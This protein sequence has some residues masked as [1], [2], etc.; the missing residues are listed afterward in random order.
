MRTLY[1]LVGFHVPLLAFLMVPLSLAAA[2]EVQ[3]AAAPSCDH[4]LVGFQVPHLTF[5]LYCRCL[6]AALEVQSVAVQRVIIA[7]FGF[8]SAFRLS[9]APV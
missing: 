8:D 2:L 7:W 4:C 5:L 6:T 1:C 3:P 9:C